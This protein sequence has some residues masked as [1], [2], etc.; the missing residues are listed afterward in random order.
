MLTQND[1]LNTLVKGKKLGGVCVWINGYVLIHELSC[2]S[3]RILNDKQ[4]KMIYEFFFEFLRKT[5]QDFL[6]RKTA[7]RLLKWRLFIFDACDLRCELYDFHAPSG[8]NKTHPAMLNFV[9]DYFKNAPKD[10]VPP[11]YLQH[12]GK[13][14]V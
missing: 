3:G 8:P 10:F 2:K 4:L 7:S 11:L 1:P 6:F 9:L 12:Q 13:F 14:G 5:L